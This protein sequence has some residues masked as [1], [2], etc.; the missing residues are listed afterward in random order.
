VKLT[1]LGTRGEIEA[2]TPLHRMHSSLLV[3]WRRK[4]VM[5]DCG[6]DWA[7]NV[8]RIGPDAILLTHAHSD[9]VAGLKTG[10]FCPVYAAAETWSRICTARIASKVVI[11][12]RCRFELFGIG[13]EAFPV[14]HSIRAPAVG[15]RITAGR[16]SVFYVPDL[17]QIRDRSEA[18]R[19]I[20]LYIGDGASITRGILR[21]R[22]KTVIGHASIRTQIQWCKEEGVR[23][24][25]FS[26][27]G[28][29]IVTSDPE[30]AARKVRLLG[31]DF[32]VD[33]RIAY[34]GLSVTL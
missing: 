24:A 25:I 26:H 20:S 7:G 13:F 10:A 21:R 11:R 32:G 23:R 22:G 33:A 5:I 31:S 28:S 3:S 15:Y 19:A 6:A 1:F 29:E 30:E 2:R 34:D 8:E 12:S 27:C 9:H 4:A 14:E 17:V 18:L 16:H